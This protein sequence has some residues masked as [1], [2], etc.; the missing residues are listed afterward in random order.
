MTVDEDD[1][2]KLEKVKTELYPPSKHEAL[3][4]CWADAGPSSTTLAHRQPNIGPMPRV[5]W[6][7]L[8]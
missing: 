8:F 5:C 3:A 1:N 7:I 4:Q 6:A 2:G